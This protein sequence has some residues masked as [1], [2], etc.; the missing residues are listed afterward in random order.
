MRVPV[1]SYDGK[2]LM[3]TK[4]SRARRWIKE[5]KAIG[6]WSKLNVFYVQL[7]KPASDNKLQDVVVGIDPGKM[8]TG[9]A[10]L[11]QKETLLTAHVELPFK[12]VTKRMV[13]RSMMRRGRRGRRINRKLPFDKRSH[14]Q[15][16]FNNRRQEGMPPSVKASKNLELRL[17]RLIVDLYPVSHVVYEVVKAKGNKGFSPVMVGQKLICKKL[18]S[19]TKLFN[20]TTREGYETSVTRK[21]LRLEK[22]KGNKSLQIPQT[23]AVDGIALAATHWL[24]YT[25]IDKNSMGSKGELTLTDSIFLIVSRPPISRR[26]LHLMVPSKGGKRRKYGGTVTQHGYRKGDYVEATKA[27][28]TYRGWVSGDT[29]TQVSISDANW[30]RLGQFTSKKVNLIKRST[31]LIVTSQKYKVHGG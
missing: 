20:F 2:P 12:N 13:Q 15:N 7:L 24:K 14:R 19:A 3:P 23:H 10:V 17:L 8:F 22:E 5:G 16:R 21:H 18:S 11:S 28:K 29:K 4:S 6:K 25:A 27:D 31:G 30:K 9:I 26:Q 1:I